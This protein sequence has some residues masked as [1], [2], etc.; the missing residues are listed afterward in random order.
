MP[1]AAREQVETEIEEML[2][3]STVDFS[4]LMPQMQYAYAK[5]L[6]YE[7]FANEVRA[8]NFELLGSLV[9]L[10]GH[11]TGP[12]TGTTGPGEDDGI[13]AELGYANYASRVDTLVSRLAE[14]AR[15]GNG[16]HGGGH[17]DYT[18]AHSRERTD[19]DPVQRRLV[20]AFAHR[21]YFR[22]LYGAV[23]E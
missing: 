7:G 13:D 4:Y 17:V 5:D 8:L 21:D 19:W 11:A 10:P 12:S 14:R 3:A 20:E 2:S 9:R 1:A 23:G 18:G 22:L 15:S 16:S 6:G